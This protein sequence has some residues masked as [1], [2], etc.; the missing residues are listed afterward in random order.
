M[1]NIIIVGSGAGGAVAA[2]E[3]Q[4][5]FHVTVLEAGGEFR[6]FSLPV[7][8]FE[9]LRKT[10]LLFDEREIQ[11]LFPQMRVQ[12]TGDQMVMVSGSCLGGTTT[13]SAGNAV[14]AD[15]GLQELGIDLEEEFQEL[16]RE[17]PITYDHRNHWSDASKRLYEICEE[18]DLDPKPI[19][20]LGDYGQCT[21]CG[22]CLLGCRYGVKWDSRRFL[23]D[24][25]EKGARAVSGCKVLKVVIEDGLVKGIQARKGLHA[26]F[27][28]ADLV[29][30][31]A[32]GF[33]T[34]VILQQSGINC[35]SSLFVDPVLCVAAHCKGSLQ[36][37]ELSMPF[38]VQKE[39]YIL[40]PYFD[41][42]SF[43]FNKEWRNPASD[44]LSLMIKLAD[45]CAGSVDGR[46]IHKSLTGLDKERLREGVGICRKILDRYGIREDEIFLGTINAGHPG[47]ML[48]LTREQAESFHD[49]RLPK[50]LYVADASLFPGSLGNPPILTIMAMAKRISKIIMERF[51]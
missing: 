42:L 44:T 2:K 5:S 34:P 51:I 19:P 23:K 37:K 31:A 40:S 13:L 22:R 6:P 24:A 15:S 10:G 36:N 14:R 9:K 20:K 4:G 47:G 45:S 33:S 43:F 35:E 32:G 11:L 49:P 48:P 38:A 39:H 50:N 1:K 16:Y 17:I 28:P 26:A 41:Y 30:L 7:S 27:Y 3:L 25:Q 12:K 18:M 46:R 29:L 8:A 21:H